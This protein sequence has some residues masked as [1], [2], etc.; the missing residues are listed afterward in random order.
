[1]KHNR[2]GQ[3]A[4]YRWWKKSHDRVDW[5][6]KLQCRAG[7]DQVTKIFTGQVTD[8]GEVALCS[9]LVSV[10]EIRKASCVKFW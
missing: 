10:A 3:A 7:Q 2:T 8:C 4:S 9:P 1:M 5:E 6:E